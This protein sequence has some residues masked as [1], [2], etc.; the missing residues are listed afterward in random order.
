MRQVKPQL[1]KTNKS[2]KCQALVYVPVQFFQFNEH[3]VYKTFQLTNRTPTYQIRIPLT[4]EL[5]SDFHIN[6]LNFTI[7]GIIFALGRFP[8]TK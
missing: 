3:P 4:Q 8:V 6:D 5:D 1:K 7:L 2:K